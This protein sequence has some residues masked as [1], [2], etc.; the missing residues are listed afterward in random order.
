[1]EY[2]FTERHYE[3]FSRH[4]RYMNNEFK[5]CLDRDSDTDDCGSSI[6]VEPF[7]IHYEHIDVD[8]NIQGELVLIYS[9]DIYCKSQEILS[10]L[11][12]TDSL[13]C[14]RR[15]LDIL[16]HMKTYLV[17]KTFRK[18]K[19]PY[20]EN[21]LHPSQDK[22]KYDGMCEKDYTFHYTRD[23][24]CPICL[25]NGGSWTKT[26]CGHFIHTSCYEKGLSN[27]K[28]SFK[29]PLCRHVSDVKKVVKHFPF[30]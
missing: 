21:T 22:E 12:S 27:K 18:C 11:I 5:M 20:C 1:M 17:G 29:C 15:Q 30:I 25:T 16:Q 3:I 9:V 10:Y 23:E 26:E 7:R 28:R 19:M 4:I 24:D 6:S 8:E 14:A 13:V 2:T